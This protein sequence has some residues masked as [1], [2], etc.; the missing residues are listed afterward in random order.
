MPY[1]V[2]ATILKPTFSPATNL[3]HNATKKK[4]AK[5]NCST[6]LYHSGSTLGVK[7]SNFLYDNNEKSIVLSTKS[8]CEAALTHVKAEKMWAHPART[9]VNT[10]MVKGA[11]AAGI[12]RPFAGAYNPPVLQLWIFCAAMSPTGYGFPGYPGT[13]VPSANLVEVAGIRTVPG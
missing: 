11:K 2:I 5:P 8:P 3:C 9:L 12:S 1:A 10:L 7:C 4:N 13:R 6:E